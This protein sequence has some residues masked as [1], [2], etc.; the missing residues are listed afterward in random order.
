M[1]PSSTST[2]RG[3]SERDRA[4]LEL[5]RPHLAQAYLQVRERT[6]TRSLLAALED[7]L[8][9]VGSALLVL[10]H[11]NQ[12]E[13]VGEVAREL[14]AAYSTTRSRGGGIL[15]P[16]RIRSWLERSTDQSLKIRGPRGLLSVRRLA[17]AF[18]AGGCL[19]VLT[20]RRA[21]PPPVSSLRSEFSLTRRQAEV[22]RL[23]C[24]GRGTDAIARDLA[25]RPATVR[26]HLEHIFARSG[27]DSRS[28]AVAR[29]L[30]AT[31]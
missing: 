27:V 8:E 20:E 14:L 4:I 22:L 10:N 21:N 11:R 15:L 5:I 31:K 6:L 1:R 9:H 13:H 16:A 23:L 25:I 26:K 28:A 17:A 2:R 24:A 19:L 3:F 12:V 7:E 30:S 29:A 18:P